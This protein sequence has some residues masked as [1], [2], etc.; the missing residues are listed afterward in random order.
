YL[1]ANDEDQAGDDLALVKKLITANKLLQD[2]VVVKAKVVERLDGRGFL[3]IV[4]A[5]DVV[6]SHGRTFRFVGFDEI[7]GY[8]S[9]DILEALQFG[10][11]RTDS[12]QW[13]TSYASI[14]HRPGVPLHDL[15]VAGRAG[16]DPRMFFSWYGADYCSDPDSMS[17][18]PEERA[19]PSRGS[20]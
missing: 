9:W 12:L 17:L 20:W 1:L 10:P 11:T 19:N 18:L 15:M 2:E 16:R 5:G 3:E 4:P 7:H 14:Y 6:G 8:R 13:I